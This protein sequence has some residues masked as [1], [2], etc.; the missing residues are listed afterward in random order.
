MPNISTNFL[1]ANGRANGGIKPGSDGFVVSVPLRCLGKQSSK[2]RNARRKTPPRPAHQEGAERVL[3]LHN[4]T[5]IKKQYV[6][7][8]DAPGWLL[9][10]IGDLVKDDLRRPCAFDLLTPRFFVL[11]IRLMSAAVS[12]RSCLQLVLA[13]RPSRFPTR[14]KGE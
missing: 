11:V 9:L 6:L 10:R 7:L 12:T 8:L 4:H 2:H 3:G 1:A 5:H 14:R 13:A